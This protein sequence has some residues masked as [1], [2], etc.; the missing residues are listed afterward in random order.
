MPKA[1]VHRKK[2]HRVDYNDIEVICRIEKACKAVRIGQVP[3]LLVASKKF[4]ICYGTLRNRY[5]SFS[6]PTKQAHDHEKLLDD[7]QEKVLVDWI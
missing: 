4:E 3:N 1:K 6:Q 2:A 5:N 7:V